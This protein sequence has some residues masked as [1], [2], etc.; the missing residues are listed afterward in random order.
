MWRAETSRG[1]TGSAGRGC[2]FSSW[3]CVDVGV[4][5]WG[6]LSA[7]GIGASGLCCWG[8]LEE[9]L[10]PTGSGQSI[11]GRSALNIHWRTDV[12]LRLQCWPCDLRNQLIVG[13]LMLGGIEGRGGGWGEGGQQRMRWLGVA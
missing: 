9:S 4:G 1:P 3:L 2:G 11:L 8:T 12:R 6:G 10:G 5:P 7:K 13:R